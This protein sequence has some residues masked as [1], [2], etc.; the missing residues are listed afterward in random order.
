MAGHQMGLTGEDLENP[1]L[2]FL[3][4][5]EAMHGMPQEF[6]D[7]LAHQMLDYREE[8]KQ[9]LTALQT[10]QGKPALALEAGVLESH[11]RQG[12]KS[13]AGDAVAA[14]RTAAAAYGQAQHRET[15]L[16][17][18]VRSLS[19]KYLLALAGFLLLA[20]IVIGFLGGRAIDKREEK[21]LPSITLDAE[22]VA[23]RL[24]EKFPER[25]P[26]KPPSGKR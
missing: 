25:C 7:I 19:W 16:V 20:G 3:K 10:I 14:L 8:L 24:A 12:A 9:V 23:E 21:P 17:D 18:Q 26:G 13:G 2:A 5:A 1:A 6:T 15:T 22:K 4:M 11:A